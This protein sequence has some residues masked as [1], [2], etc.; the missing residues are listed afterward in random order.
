MQDT[1]QIIGI[2]LGTALSTGLLMYSFPRR[3]KSKKRKSS[4]VATY[5]ELQELVRASIKEVDLATALGCLSRK[6]NED[7]RIAETFDNT[8]EAHPFVMCRASV[9]YCL[10]LALIRCHDHRDDS[11]GL[12]ALFRSLKSSETMANLRQGILQRRRE[13][14]GE[15]EAQQDLVDHLGQIDEAK[16]LED[17]IKGSQKFHRVRTFRHAHVAHRARDTTEVEP[18]E[19]EWL[20]E[21]TDSSKDIV[22][23]LC[24]AILG[25]SEDFDGGKEIWEEYTRLFFDSMMERAT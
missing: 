1:L 5:P 16:E 14:V 17:R 7:D 3:P 15:E 8:Y 6:F 21:L 25:S 2:V 19:R 13:W 11:H 22:Q 12:T 24:G 9:E 10:A 4:A 23:L 18:A 20:Y